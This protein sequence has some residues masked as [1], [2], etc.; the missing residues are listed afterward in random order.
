MGVDG[1]GVT[2]KSFKMLG[3]TKT[4]EASAA[5]E[6]VALHG[7]WRSLDMP[8]RYKHNSKEFKL[9]TATKV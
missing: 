2:D 7:R 8:L 9:K 4:V 1:Q 3:V 5:A 6:E